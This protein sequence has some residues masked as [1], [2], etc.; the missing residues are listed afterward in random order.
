[1][2]VVTAFAFCQFCQCPQR[3]NALR[4]TVSLIRWRRDQ[5]IRHATTFLRKDAT[6]G[7]GNGFHYRFAHFFGAAV[8]VV[9]RV[10][11]DHAPGQIPDDL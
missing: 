7:L 9:R 3:G 5:R 8:E 2:S 11:V 6:Q 4:T 10:L 1:M